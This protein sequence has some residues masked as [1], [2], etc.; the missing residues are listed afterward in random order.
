MDKLQALKT[1]R[2]RDGKEKF[3]VAKL[4][5]HKKGD[6][7]ESSNSDWTEHLVKKGFAKRIST[8]DSAVKNDESKKKAKKKSGE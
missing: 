7:F 6:F 5:I 2:N 4:P 8:E 3:D 1:F